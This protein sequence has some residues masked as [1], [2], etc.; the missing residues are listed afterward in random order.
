M[1]NTVSGMSVTLPIAANLLQAFDTMGNATAVSGTTTATI[2][3]AAQRPTY[4]QCASSNYSQLKTA[5]STMTVT[6]T[7]PVTVTASPVAGGVQV[8]VTGTSSVA[9]DGIVSLVSAKQ[10]APA[11]WPAAQRFQGLA[12]GQSVTLRFT[13]PPNSTVS[14]IQVTAGDRQLQTV[15]IPYTIR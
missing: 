10:P 6:A 12:S 7:S 2:Q 13:L 4:L 11:G 5:V 9:V 15:T 14:Q 1:W 3:M 8:T